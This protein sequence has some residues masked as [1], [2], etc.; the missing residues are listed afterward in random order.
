VAKQSFQGTPRENHRTRNVAN[1]TG[2][3]VLSFHSKVVPVRTNNAKD[4]EAASAVTVRNKVKLKES[5]HMYRRHNTSRRPVSLASL[6]MALSCG[7]LFLLYQMARFSF[8]M[9]KDL[10]SREDFVVKAMQASKTQV[11]N[12][13]I[14]Y[15]F[16]LGGIPTTTSASDNTTGY[17]GL[18]YNILV[19]VQVLRSLGSKADMVLMVHMAEAYARLPSTDLEMIRDLNI[20]IQYVPP[21][22]P[23]FHNG[24]AT[25]ALEKFRILSWTQYGRVLYLNP[26]VMP[27]CNLD[28]LMQLSTKGRL[29]ENVLIS[30]ANQPLS[31]SIFVVAPQ[32]DHYKRF[33]QILK[34]SYPDGNKIFNINR[35][36]GHAFEHTGHTFG[37]E[38]FWDT[39]KVRQ[40]GQLGKV[41]DYIKGLM[42]KP[43]Q[44]PSQQW[45]F[46]GAN[47]DAG[48][49]Y[50]WVRFVRQRYSIIVGESIYTRL[51]PGSMDSQVSSSHALLGNHSC[52]L[53]KGD[54]SQGSQFDADTKVQKNASSFGIA[55]LVQWEHYSRPPWEYQKAPHPKLEVTSP[56]QF[57]FQTLSNLD[58]THHWNLGLAEVSHQQLGVMPEVLDEWKEKGPVEKP[59]WKSSPG[60]HKQVN[61]TESQRYPVWST[62]IQALQLWGAVQSCERIKEQNWQPPL[63]T[64]PHQDQDPNRRHLF[65]KDPP[66]PPH[67][68]QPDGRTTL[69][70]VIPC[71]CST[72]ISV[73]PCSL[74]DQ[75][76][77]EWAQSRI[78]IK[79]SKHTPA[80]PDGARNDMH[81]I[82]PFSNVDSQTIHDAYCSVKCQDYPTSKVTIYLYQD[83][84]DDNE[85]QVLP[86]ICDLKNILELKPPVVASAMTTNTDTEHVFEQ[87]ANHWAAVV[88][89]D[90]QHKRLS[91]SSSVSPNAICFHSKDHAGR[92][93]AKYWAFRL[94]QANANANDV[95]VVVD[96]DDELSTPKAL[97]IINRK[98][99]EMSAWMT[100]GSHQGKYSEQTKDIP[101]TYH[102]GKEPWSPRRES[103][104]WR[105]G[106]PQTFKAHLLQ[107]VSRKDFTFR[108]GS[109]LIKATDRGFFY[110]ML[111]VA[112][113]DR[114]GYIPQ[115]I[116]K[117]KW[118]ATLSTSAQVPKEMQEAQL[119]HVVNLTPSKRVILPIHVVLVCWG[120]VYIL[121]DQLEWLQQQDSAEK[122]Q[123]TI[124]LL[125]N[126]PEANPEIYQTIAH[127]EKKQQDGQFENY[128]PLKIKVVEN[129]V[130]WHAF[131]RFVYTNKLRKTE[132]MD[133]VIFVDDD[134]FFP[135]NF[136]SSLLAYFK[137]RGMTTWYGK[138]FSTKETGMANFWNPMI[139]WENLMRGELDLDAFAYGG[140]GGSVF[141]V[142]LWLFEQQLMRLTGDLKDY[143]PFDDLW[144]S[145]VIDALLGWELRR[146]PSLPIDIANCHYGIYDETVF[147]SLPKNQVLRLRQMNKAMKEQ[148]QSVA[149]FLNKTLSNAK[150]AMFADL[151]SRFF[152]HVDRVDGRSW[153]PN[154]YTIE[155]LDMVGIS[156]ILRP[157]TVVSNTR[158]AFVC[159]TG[160]LAR[161][162][163]T[164]KIE[165]ILRPLSRN[166]YKIDVA[167]VL[168]GGNPVFTNANFT[169]QAGAKNAPFYDRLSKAV[170]DLQN[171]SNVTLISP[172][173]EESGLYEAI[174]VN[175][176]PPRYL[177]FMHKACSKGRSLTEQISR[178][179]NHARIFESYQRCLLYAEREIEKVAAKEAHNTASRL[180]TI[181]NYYDV[182]FR[183]RDD[184]GFQNP[185][186]QGL[187]SDLATPPPNSITV[188]SCRGW[189]G[190]NDRFA[191]VSPDAARL[192]FK[193]PY[194]LFSAQEDM[195]AKYVRNP[196][197]FLLF[198]YLTAGIN[199]YGMKSLRW[200]VRMYKKDGQASISPDDLEQQVCPE[201]SKSTQALLQNFA[202]NF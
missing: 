128:V 164:S 50:H 184:V 99:L 134:Q 32:Q 9:V 117:Y 199:V 88:M 43:R 2:R 178:A 33:L 159:I 81:I 170:K 13:P 187:I 160:Q 193:L 104:S 121:K 162:E 31:T 139:T 96:G 52:L 150:V 41:W 90:Y 40:V 60:Q 95:I 181:E 115:A 34:K 149:T 54:D 17:R 158:R 86:Q 152:W 28:Y 172:S 93:G 67:P 82:L 84:D 63:V 120:R 133:F 116:Y 130:N 73:D 64:W 137:P 39:P 198:S 27:L 29:G 49:L 109:W 142:N 4:P 191:S 74:P 123:M 111:E 5:K 75:T 53:T 185:L 100:Y 61:A 174:A 145:Y 20:L 188:S 155:R 23:S 77:E 129:K 65:L 202:W 79:F 98:Y 173:D 140:P 42:V 131:S 3:F 45:I 51:S 141:D 135:P 78:G 102:E 107:H 30:I 112:G 57:W 68:Q 125:S 1:Q 146:Q 91:S 71:Q 136:V 186:Q 76:L 138:T 163:L 105:F 108:D 183:L 18:L 114:V 175:K 72:L 161:L 85:S 103:P 195:S 59:T 87:E 89:K 157:K 153:Q 168:T 197:T 127:F 6:R 35:G 15:A 147:L 70:S 48:L 62:K 200:M 196:E 148:L 179:E 10:E 92:G 165:N 154:N 69:S 176:V 37:H 189:G 16:F 110:R 190:M 101:T 169:K 46:E 14:A 118:S 44:S 151:T 83:G 22:V 21:T 8:M 7:I 167:F 177:N 119:E 66:S 80:C 144:A 24:F 19:S 132:A 36:W 182:Y 171:E 192:Y 25:L 166:G 11:K 58:A 26:D 55:D 97:Q 180:P 126:N 12:N 47:S 94:V 194:T 143:H 156:P 122:Q 201:Y 113:V 124:H 38:E 106:H 56:Q